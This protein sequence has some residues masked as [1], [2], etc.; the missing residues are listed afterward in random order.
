MD[1]VCFP[2]PS[3]ANTPRKALFWPPAFHGDHWKG[4]LMMYFPFQSRTYTS[5]ET[6]SDPALYPPPYRSIDRSRSET[7]SRSGASRNKRLTHDAVARS[8]F[9]AGKEAREVEK[10]FRGRKRDGRAR[11]INCQPRSASA[12]IRS[13]RRFTVTVNEFLLNFKQRWSGVRA[14]GQ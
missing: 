11:S 3:V 7:R 8:Q 6:V 9:A 2:G 4:A 12:P 5:S 13:Y 10:S 14:D 1:A